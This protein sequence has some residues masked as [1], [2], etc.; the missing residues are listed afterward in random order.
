MVGVSSNRTLSYMVCIVT[1]VLFKA[2]SKGTDNIEAEV[3]GRGSSEFKGRADAR[4]NQ[5]PDRCGC[6]GASSRSCSAKTTS[7]SFAVNDTCRRFQCCILRRKQNLTNCEEES[8]CNS[9][10]TDGSK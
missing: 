4:D 8:S 6:F 5:V 3:S 7:T 1:T 9:P 2:T 10:C